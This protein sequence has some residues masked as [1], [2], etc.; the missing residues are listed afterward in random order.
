MAG[1]IKDKS[2]HDI[3]ANV[4]REAAEVVDDVKD[5][6]EDVEE[7]FH[8]TVERVRNTEVTL[9]Q[10]LLL[11]GSVAVIASVAIQNIVRRFRAPEVI[12]NEYLV[13]PSDVVEDD[14]IVGET[15]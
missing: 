6:A 2:I 9:N 11:V 8:E 12:V 3:E 10:K 1:S 14:D 4:K 7:K 13:V 15:D 5:A